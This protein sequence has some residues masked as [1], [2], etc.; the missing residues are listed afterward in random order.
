[1]PTTIEL[2][3]ETAP[4]TRRSRHR[5][6]VLAAL[7]VLGT[8]AVAMGSLTIANQAMEQHERGSFTASEVRGLVVEVDSGNVTLVP[9][10]DDGGQVDVD[11]T[12]EWAWSRPSTD[13][14]TEDGVL[15]ITADCPAVGLGSC[16]VDHRIAVPAG[17]DVDVDLSSG[18]VTATG[19]DLAVVDV[20]TDSGDIARRT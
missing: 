11:S 20:S 14:V 6:A 7:G 1:M 19:L 16:S 3:P 12:M 18:N 10:A 2:P 8:L 9:T 5:S 4:P 17:I 15:T 13:H